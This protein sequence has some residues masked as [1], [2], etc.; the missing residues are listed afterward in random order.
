MT[1]SK[2]FKNHKP[3][4]AVKLRRKDKV[5]KTF[6]YEWWVVSI[7]FTNGTVDCE[8]KGKNK[9]NII[10]QIKK[11]VKEINSG[12]RGYQPQIIEVY[13]E[14]LRLDRIGYQRLS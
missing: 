6:N 9:E 12:K 4:G 13:W 1:K 10:R 7:H 8:F 3:S 11:E 14:T 2:R 5:M